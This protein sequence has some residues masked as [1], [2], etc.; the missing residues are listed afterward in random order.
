MTAKEYLMQCKD[1]RKRAEVIAEE[2]AEL[3]K[4]G[5]DVS[6]YDAEREKYLALRTKVYNMIMQMQD[7]DEALILIYRYIQGKKW[8][9]IADM[10]G[11]TLQWVHKLHQRA[12]ESFA[13]QYR[14]EL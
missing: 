9:T 11:F 6:E 12:L 10:T 7:I 4:Y 14:D 5:A 8:T 3:K 2:A 1:C 13:I